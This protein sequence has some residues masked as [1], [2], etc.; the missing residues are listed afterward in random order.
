MSAV[1]I[2]QSKL[3]EIVIPNAGM[4]QL[5]ALEAG[6]GCVMYKR[7]GKYERLITLTTN[8]QQTYYLQPGDYTIEWRSKSLK[9]SIYTIEKK[10]NI[11]PDQATV[12]ELYK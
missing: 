9:G 6:D 3:N 2:E 4:L 7:D 10:F 1:K 8:T 12:V 5:K 11:K